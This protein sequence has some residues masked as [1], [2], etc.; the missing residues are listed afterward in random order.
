[1]C[2]WV[3]AIDVYPG[4]CQE[5]ASLGPTIT[6]CHQNRRAGAQG[7]AWGLTRMPRGYSDGSQLLRPLDGD[8]LDPAG[9]V[10]VA[11]AHPAT[12]GFVHFTCTFVARWA[13]EASFS[14]SAKLSRQDRVRS[15]V[16]TG[17]RQR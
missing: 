12:A 11:Q 1:M 7:Q 8:S 10:R 2:D 4:R 16:L 17:R 13:L 15:S 9:R 3:T 6:Y 14:I 5:F